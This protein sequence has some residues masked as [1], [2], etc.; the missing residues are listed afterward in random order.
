LI[1]SL[2]RIIDILWRILR[3][4]N[5]RSISFSSVKTTQA[6]HLTITN[7]KVKNLEINGRMELII[8]TINLIQY[9][10]WYKFSTPNYAIVG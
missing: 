5:P 6:I 4:T 2:I 8:V 1:A 9:S 3:I 10:I 7:H